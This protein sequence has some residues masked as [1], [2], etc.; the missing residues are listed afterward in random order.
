MWLSLSFLLASAAESDISLPPCPAAALHTSKPDGEVD[1][2][3]LPEHAFAACYQQARFWRPGTQG[4]LE[5]TMRT[6]PSGVPKCLDLAGDLADTKLGA[7]V[8][9]AVT[10]LRFDLPHPALIR[11]PIEFRPAGWAPSIDI[12]EDRYRVH[13][14]QLEEVHVSRNGR[15]LR[16]EEFGELVQDPPSVE[17]PLRSALA[18]R[19]TARWMWGTSLGVTVAG[20]VLAGANSYAAGPITSCDYT[21][22][23][24]FDDGAGNVM[25][26][27]GRETAYWSGWTAMIAGSSGVGVGLA[28]EE[29][30]AKRRRNLAPA[31]TTHE[32]EEALRSLLSESTADAAG[33]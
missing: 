25:P 31:Y 5:L 33:P 6:D 11:I 7:C 32:A 12:G 17:E 24:T 10:P 30:A 14:G 15:L 22:C 18:Q 29:F 28:L 19:R 21:T 26:Y 23:V 20:A 16:I 1:Y 8:S 2:P 27:P 9:A 3:S 13:P 4:R